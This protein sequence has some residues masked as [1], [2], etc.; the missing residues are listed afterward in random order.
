MTP[1]MPLPLRD[2][3]PG[4]APGWWPPA[5]G[6]WW[7]AGALLLVL[8]ALGVAYWRRQRR[9]RGW[10]QVFDARLAQA[11]SG[12]EQVA[13]ISELLRRAA[14]RIDP[15]ADRLQG[16]DWLRVL[17]AGVQPPVFAAGPGR[18]LLDGLYRR[19]VDAAALE[20]LRVLAR[21]RFLQWMQ[22]A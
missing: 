7:L 19:E 14:R 13:A 2:V 16:E 6:W 12:P 4:L 5:P 22:R 15:A 20:A 3:H 9:M 11:R 17:D 8:A 1:A 21:R 10:A 18:L